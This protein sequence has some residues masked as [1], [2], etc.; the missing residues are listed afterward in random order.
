MKEP[1]NRVNNKEELK[2]LKL[3]S[4]YKKAPLKLRGFKLKRDSYDTRR[5]ALKPGAIYLE[6]SNHRETPNFLN[7]I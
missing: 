7:Y 4:G 5:E 6:D 3:L 2:A 1:I